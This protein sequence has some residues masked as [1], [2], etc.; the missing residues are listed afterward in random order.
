MLQPS[1]NQSVT[2]VG[3]SLICCDS[4]MQGPDPGQS[5]VHVSNA[6]PAPGSWVVQETQLGL[7][8]GD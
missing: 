4:L 7:P 2:Q 3:K 6:L 5:I 1:C 8:V